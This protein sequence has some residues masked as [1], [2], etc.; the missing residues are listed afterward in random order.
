MPLEKN[1]GIT[2]EILEYLIGKQDLFSFPST[3]IYKNSHK[4]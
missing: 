3:T 2:Y 1:L 4:K